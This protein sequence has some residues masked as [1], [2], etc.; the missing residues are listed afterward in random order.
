[1][2]GRVHWQAMSKITRINLIVNPDMR[3][4]WSFTAATEGITLSA[5]IRQ[6]CDRAALP[7]ATLEL[8]RRGIKQGR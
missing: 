2:H 7:K 8:A 5:W 4:R 6:A 1:M 3:Q